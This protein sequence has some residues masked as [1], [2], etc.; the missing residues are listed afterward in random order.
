VVLLAALALA[1]C[2]TPGR[3]VIVDLEPAPVPPEPQFVARDVG[4]LL[5][6]DRGESLGAERRLTALDAAGR[7]AL[8]EHAQRIPEERDPRWL[9]VL[10]ENDLLPPLPANVHL[11]YLLWKSR[12]AEDFYVMKAQARLLDFAGRDPDAM[13]AR[14]EAGGAGAEALAVA[15]A[16]AGERR[17]VP[18]LLARYRFASSEGERRV[19]AEALGRLLGEQRRPRALGSP[20]EIEQ[21]ARAVER[22]YRDVEVP[23]DG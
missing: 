22:W 23:R 6:A 1:S 4:R 18:P 10:D 17:A 3:N 13:L 14:L 16:L 7:A 5:S 12:R 15:L 11:D 8:A 9:H 19:A 2:G 20:E 21:D